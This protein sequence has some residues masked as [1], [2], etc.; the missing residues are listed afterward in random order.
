MRIPAPVV[1]GDL[2][3]DLGWTPAQA[4]GNLPHQD[5]S[6]HQGLDLASF[7]AGQLAVCSTPPIPRVLH[8][9]VE[10]GGVS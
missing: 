9:R 1:A 4:S 6:G 10:W 7:T 5:A 8:F 2:A 3:A